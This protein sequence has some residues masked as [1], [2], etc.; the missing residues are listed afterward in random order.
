[1]TFVFKNGRIFVP[2]KTRGTDDNDFAQGMVIEND[3]ITQ[4]GSLDEIH[5]PSDATVVDLQNR[6]VIPGFIDGHVHIL[7]Y[8]QSLCKVNL[9]QCKSL[10]QIRQAI[11]DY[12]KQ[13]PSIPRILCQGWMQSSI[14][15]NPLA[16]MI[17]DLDP[18]P[19]YIDAFDLHSIW[20]NSAALDEMG[21]HTAP[22]LP[23]GT[24]HR[25]RNGK[26][27][28]LISEATMMR[29]AWPFLESVT[30]TNDKLSALDAAV[31][32]YTSAGYT[33]IVDMAMDD[34][35]WELLNIYRR[36][37]A[38]PFHIAAHWLV[39]FSEDQDAN[40]AHVDRAIEMSKK[41]N[42]PDFCVVGI[43]IISDGVVD[44][45][46]AAL[47]QPYTGKTD[48]VEPIWPSHLLQAVV[49]R[50]DSAGLQCAVHAIGDRAIH[51]AIN[52]LSQV[53]TPGRRHRIEHLEL[54][55]S[56]DAKRL[57]ELGITASIQPVHS[58]PM[59]FKAWPGLVGHERCKRAFA[60]REFLD[61][62]APIS[63]GTDAPT[64]RHFPLPNLYNATTRRSALEPESTNT[65]NPHFGLSLAEATAG[66][67]AG[68]AYARRAESWT[69][70]LRSGLSADFAVVDVQWTPEKL[71]EGKVCQTW[72]KG[73]KVFDG[74][75]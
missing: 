24:I 12:A 51:Q 37:K 23:G 53:G 55:S 8:G 73:R 47:H 64:A 61:G 22:D 1:M 74:G 48:P 71:L 40:F 30:S 6:I 56:E 49:Q 26:A 54:T 4:V 75:V 43:K 50:A 70:E 34:G 60:Y 13:N 14:E 29:L 5:P 52:V 59:L 39:P 57:G 31:T 25:D 7:H 9:I 62:G 27:S 38:I 45:C 35:Q 28:G 32:T 46:T 18:R 36:N 44:G 17:D 42:Q 3:R 68:A 65:V 67:T 58:D 69:G 72:Y 66:A 11:A 10:D 19:I 2:S 63:I 33:G 21:A 20:C 15:G 41:F 16:T